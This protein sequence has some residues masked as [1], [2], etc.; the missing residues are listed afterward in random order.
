MSNKKSNGVNGKGYYIALA[1]CAIAIGV[2][3]YLYYSNAGD[4]TAQP[5]QQDAAVSATDPILEQDVPAVA[6]Q[7]QE[8]TQE[9]ENTQATKPSVPVT[10]KPIRTA[11]PLEGQTVAVY[12]MDA[13]AYNQTT[14]DWRT[15]NGI[16]IA[17]EEGTAV[18]AAADGTV[19]TV[20]EDETMG[21]TVVIRHQDGYVT[22][23]ASLA[24]EVA[25]KPG[26]KVELGQKIGCV[27]DTALLESAIGC[28]LH[29]G[30]T[31]N[32]EPVNPAEFLELN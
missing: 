3:G 19:Y 6:T 15:H 21:M 2:S 22:K 7:P 26:D 23:Y 11:S 30:V 5:D 13:L 31:R 27:G 14:R 25:V 32:D 17:A 18:R 8:Q 10:T 16:D 24:E 1:L 9:K 20:Y 12:A 29:F 28:H 4:N